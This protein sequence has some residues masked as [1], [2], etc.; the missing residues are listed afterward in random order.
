MEEL[1]EE[2]WR[3]SGRKNGGEG[4]RMEELREEEWRS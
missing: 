2:K 3:S 4:G 1:R